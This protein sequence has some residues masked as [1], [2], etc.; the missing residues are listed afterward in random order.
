MGTSKSNPGLKPTPL[1]PSWA[2]NPP[3]P[4]LEEPDHNPDKQQDQGE[5][6]QQNTDDQGQSTEPERG[7]WSNAKLWITNYIKGTTRSERSRSLKRAA[8]A[9]VRGS[10]G[11]HK[12]SASAVHG[13]NAAIRLGGVLSGFSSE[14]TNQ[15]FEKLG[16]GDLSNMSIE[17]AFSKLAQY[18]CA[19]GSTTEESV[20]NAAVIEALSQLYEEFDLE[21]GDLENLDSLSGDQVN[22]IIERYISSYIFERWI[23]ELGMSIEG[24]DDISPARVVSFEVEIKEFIDANVNLEF[25][26]MNLAT[27]NLGQEGTRQ[28]IE[29]I[30]LQ[31]Y[32]Q[33]EAL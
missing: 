27:L 23:H 33:I 13:K 17:V 15:T 14:G 30:F 31:A 1:L 10:G 22:E 4:Q 25:S 32:N 24:K 9:Y 29:S 28:L 26:G 12:I 20:A 6:N 16:L 2:P 3:E 7:D 5:R 19:E 21:N 11:A 8:Q 18:L